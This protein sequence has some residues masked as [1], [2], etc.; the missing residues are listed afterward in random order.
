MPT[1]APKT[2]SPLPL[3]SS[4]TN[5]VGVHRAILITSIRSLG[6]TATTRDSYPQ[7]V[8]TLAN[9]RAARLDEV[10]CPEIGQPRKQAQKCP[11]LR[12]F[13]SA[14]TSTTLC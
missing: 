12:Q 10:N 13:D 6:A 1:P 9:Q 2:H 5:F 8:R 7:P 3:P 11:Y 4:Q 14:L